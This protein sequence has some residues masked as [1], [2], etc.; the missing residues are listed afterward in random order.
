[1]LFDRYVLRNMFNHVMRRRAYLLHHLPGPDKQQ[2]ALGRAD[3]LNVYACSIVDGSTLNFAQTCLYNQHHQVNISVDMPAEVPW[4]RR[5][6]CDQSRDPAQ[7]PASLTN[8][9][10]RRLKV[11]VCRV[12]GEAGSE[13]QQ[14][15]RP[16]QHRL[17]RLL[18]RGAWLWRR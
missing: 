8:M 6:A 15:P 10:S 1:M 9:P 4:Q 5:K 14:P 2:A 3:S 17:E 18:L 13:A 12:G 11:H 16:S 7:C